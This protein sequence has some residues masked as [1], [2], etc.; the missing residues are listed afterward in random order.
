[1]PLRPLS[2]VLFLAL[3]GAAGS[4]HAQ[5][6]ARAATPEPAADEPS[7]VADPAELAFEQGRWEDAIREYRAI[8]AD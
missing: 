4:I 5:G 1:M 2:V 7:A 3:A 8:L 6:T